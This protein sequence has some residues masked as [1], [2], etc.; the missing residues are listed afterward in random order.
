MPS[1]GAGEAAGEVT[2]V[3]GV[4]QPARGGVTAWRHGPVIAGCAA[5]PDPPLRVLAPEPHELGILAVPAAACGHGKSLQA[6]GGRPGGRGQGWV[7]ARRTGCAMQPRPSPRNLPPGSRGSG[8]RRPSHHP[9]RAAGRSRYPRDQGTARTMP[10]ARTAP[11]RHDHISI[12]IARCVRGGDH[13]VADVPGWPGPGAGRYQLPARG[14]QLAD[15]PDHVRRGPPAQ[16]GRHRGRAPDVR[17]RH[18][19]RPRH[20]GRR[21]TRRSGRQA[22]NVGRG[23]SVFAAATRDHGPVPI[24]GDARPGATCPGAACSQTRA[25][26]AGSW[27]VIT[28]AAAI[29]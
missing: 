3:A 8:F 25:V 10:P 16:R 12:C 6:A 26:P 17:P 28:F 4:D 7:R 21:G 24:H 19:R 29:V 9:N 20:G 23:A 13:R 2:D 11:R 27:Q 5:A 14:D 22:S 1:L 15:G 18:R